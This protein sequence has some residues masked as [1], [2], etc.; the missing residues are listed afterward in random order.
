MDKDASFAV[1]NVMCAITSPSIGF[2]ADH[3]SGGIITW[4]DDRRDHLQ[5]A[6]G[7]PATPRSAFLAA[8]AILGC[9]IAQ[10]YDRFDPDHAGG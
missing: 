2:L 5:Y 3:L 1:G 6:R 9:M 4:A 7:Y 8:Q 10:N